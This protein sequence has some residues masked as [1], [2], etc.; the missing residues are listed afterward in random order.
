MIT[1]TGRDKALAADMKQLIPVPVGGYVGVLAL[2]T[3][4]VLIWD[5][6]VVY[7]RLPIQ[8]AIHNSSK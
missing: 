4:W 8:T 7:E 5:G 2:R 3:A 1:G 6:H